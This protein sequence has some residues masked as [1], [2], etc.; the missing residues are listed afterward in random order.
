MGSPVSKLRSS[1]LEISASHCRRIL[2]FSIQ[3]NS[4]LFIESYQ[5][6]MD[7]I[8]EEKYYNRLSLEEELA[9]YERVQAFYYASLTAQ[10]WLKMSRQDTA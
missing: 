2:R 6:S 5:H 1:F 7:W 9:A 4:N 8:E 10:H 3:P